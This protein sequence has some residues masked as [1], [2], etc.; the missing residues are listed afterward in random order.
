MK[1]SVRAKRM[2][3]RLRKMKGSP[4][5]N[6]V[7]LMDIFTILV[8]FLMVN[9]SDVEIL[10]QND[11]IKLP[12]SVAERR[13]RENI[14]ILVNDKEIIVQGRK[15]VNVDEISRRDETIAALTSELSHHASRSTVTNQDTPEHA[16][17]IMGN[18]NIPYQL[19]KQVM[20]TCADANYTDISLAV[21]KT[22]NKSSVA[23]EV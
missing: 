14:M 13:P 6:L 21:T 8:F 4:T 23:P 20:T 7:S 3:K 5:L 12:E 2:N 19:L 15:V 18:H 22:A 10:Q 9:S 1:Q 11:S 17:T 16:V